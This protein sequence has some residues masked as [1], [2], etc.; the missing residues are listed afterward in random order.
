M[1]SI[2]SYSSEKPARPEPFSRSLE[3]SALTAIVDFHRTPPNKISFLSLWVKTGLWGRKNEKAQIGV[4][5]QSAMFDLV[6]KSIKEV[7]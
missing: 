2:V 3:N 6:E 4:S 7:F 5:A 1:P